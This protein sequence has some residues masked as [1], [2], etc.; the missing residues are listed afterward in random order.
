MKKHLISVLALAALILAAGC[1]RHTAPD[2]TKALAEK[3]ARTPLSI[4]PEAP[5]FFPPRTEADTSDA[6]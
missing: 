5:K 4:N 2:D 3:K 1:Q 6:R